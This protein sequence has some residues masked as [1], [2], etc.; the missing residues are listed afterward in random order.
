MSSVTIF[1]Y[2]RKR[3]KIS[4]LIVG[5]LIQAFFTFDQYAYKWG[6]LAIG[7]RAYPSLQRSGIL[8]SSKRFADFMA[9]AREVVPQDGSVVYTEGYLGG[10]TG[11]KGVMQYYLFPRRLVHCK[12]ADSVADCLQRADPEAFFLAVGDFP[13]AE[14]AEQSRRLIPFE[15]D[16]F[17]RGI[18]APTVEIEP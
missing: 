18:Y 9:L 7:L 6:R 11:H 8:F 17:Y 10:P 14:A 16:R 4:V 5:I 3:W 13:P 1:E 12:Q 15:P 2:L